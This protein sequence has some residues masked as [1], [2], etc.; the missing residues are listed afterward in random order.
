VSET[1]PQVRW[2]TRFAISLRELV[3][4]VAMLLLPGGSVLALT[5]WVVRHRGGFSAP[6]LRVLV[7]IATLSAALI[8]PRSV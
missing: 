5:L 8:L 4:Y 7:V 3:P 1:R 6:V 2:T